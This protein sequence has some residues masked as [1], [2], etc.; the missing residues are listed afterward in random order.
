MTL[1]LIFQDD[2]ALAILDP[3]VRPRLIIDA[4]IDKARVGRSHLDGAQS[5]VQAAQP[6]RAAVH[7]LRL[8]VQAQLFCR[9]GKRLRHAASHQGLDSNGIDGVLNARRH[10]SKAPVALW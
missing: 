3:E 4:L 8:Q 6:Q 1:A 10:R 2:I 5:P 7:I 9:K